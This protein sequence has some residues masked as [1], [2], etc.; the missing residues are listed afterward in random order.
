VVYSSYKQGLLYYYTGILGNVLE[1]TPP[2][3]LTI[4]EA[5]RAVDIIDKSI[6][7]VI[8]GKIT[9]DMLEGFSGWG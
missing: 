6:D 9:K 4:E 7:N 1:L 3:I 2:L 5:K 8:E